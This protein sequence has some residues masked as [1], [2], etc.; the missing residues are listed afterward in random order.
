M[1][2]NIFSCFRLL[3]GKGQNFEAG[4]GQENCFFLPIIFIFFR[5]S[6]GFSLLLD[7]SAES[8][9]FVGTSLG[10]DK[11]PITGLMQRS[12]IPCIAVKRYFIQLFP[13]L[14]QLVN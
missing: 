3:V 9:D 1:G 14:T 4:F 2:I 8:Q 5:Q 6:H 10:R 12:H 13:A 11:I 7:V